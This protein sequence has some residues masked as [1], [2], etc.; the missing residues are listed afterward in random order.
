MTK[1]QIK[2]P[3]VV[4]GKFMSYY[5][6]TEGILNTID[7]LTSSFIRQISDKQLISGYLYMPSIGNSSTFI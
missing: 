1:L 4:K 6:I 3:T 5:T 7:M 2:D